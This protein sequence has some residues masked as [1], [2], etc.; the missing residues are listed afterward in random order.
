MLSLKQPKREGG[1][2]SQKAEIMH[3]REKHG[4]RH[5]L[6]VGSQEVF[7]WVSELGFNQAAHLPWSWKEDFYLFFLKM[8]RELTL[9]EWA[10]PCMGHAGAQAGWE[11]EW[12][13]VG[14]QLA[15]VVIALWREMFASEKRWTCG[16]A[17]RILVTLLS[18]ISRDKTATHAWRVNTHTMYK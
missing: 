5:G 2:Y 12:N 7:A 18:W 16:C 14:Q 10:A 4:E 1:K 9:L 3:G 13:A 8:E 15:D 6:Q 11:G 17:C